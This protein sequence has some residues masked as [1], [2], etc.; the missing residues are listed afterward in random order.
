L[1]DRALVGKEYPPFAVTLT[2]DW[3]RQW[4]DLFALVSGL[5]A[6]QTSVPTNWPA[7]LTLHGTACLMNIWE[8]LGVDPLEVRLVG[9]EF[10]HLLPPVVGE[11]IEGRLRI[12]E[13]SECIEPETGIEEQVDFAVGFRDRFGSKLAVYACSYRIPRT[14]V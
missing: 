12:E 13:I 4:R 9:E 3:L 2:E 1:I 7:I 14:R 10:E 11:E 5:S 6:P 8:D